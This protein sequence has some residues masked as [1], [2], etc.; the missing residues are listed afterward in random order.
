[1][2]E[3]KIAVLGYAYLENSDDTRN[4]PSIPL[5]SRLEELGAEVVVHDPWVR[6]YQGDLLERVQG[7]NALVVMVAHDEYRTV[8]LNALRGRV[9]HTVV[10][11]GRNV[12]A[13]E[14]VRAAGWVY[15]GV[16]HGMR[17]GAHS[18]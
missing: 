6:E 4:S 14:A 5:I 18:D 11:D 2:E 3:A 13:A 1:I 15:R 7:C 17:V 8:D 12:F 16:G 9:A 10:V